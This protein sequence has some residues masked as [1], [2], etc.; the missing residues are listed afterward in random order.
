MNNTITHK[1]IAICND[2]MEK[3]GE[4]VGLSFYAFFAN[5][6]D[7]PALLMEVAEWWIMKHKLNHF[8]KAEK[9]RELARKEIN[10]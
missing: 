1:I 5:K 4:K 7:N 2:K 3:K 6:N 10:N 9:I 8:E